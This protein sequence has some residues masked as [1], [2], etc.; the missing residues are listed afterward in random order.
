M[1]TTQNLVTTF[2]KVGDSVETAVRRLKALGV[3]DSVILTQLIEYWDQRQE[4]LKARKAVKDSQ[5]TPE[6]EQTV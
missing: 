5:G 1:D 3:G 4:E 6:T 2:V